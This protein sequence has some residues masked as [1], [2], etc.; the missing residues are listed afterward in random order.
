MNAYSIILLNLFYIEI[1]VGL[2]FNLPLWKIL[3]PLIYVD[4]TCPI[5][6]VPGDHDFVYITSYIVLVIPKIIYLMLKRERGPWGQPEVTDPGGKDPTH[7]F[8]IS[9]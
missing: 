2:S 8:N 1:P 4:L 9:N 7:T 3:W 6:F 5:I